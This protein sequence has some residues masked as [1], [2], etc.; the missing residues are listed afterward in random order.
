MCTNEM[1]ENPDNY[2]CHIHVQKIA[3]LIKLN[4]GKNEKQ[5]EILETTL[6]YKANHCD[7]TNLTKYIFFP[8]VCIKFGKCNRIFENTLHFI[9]CLAIFTGKQVLER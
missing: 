6:N 9:G 4:F 5:G 7:I 1:C 2:S 8:S 3:L